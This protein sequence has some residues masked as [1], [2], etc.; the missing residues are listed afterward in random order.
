MKEADKLTIL[1]MAMDAEQGKEVGIGFLKGA[2]P[3]AWARTLGIKSV[4]AC[5]YKSLRIPNSFTNIA[6]D[7]RK[8]SSCRLRSDRQ[9]YQ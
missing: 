6:R 4:F 3:T 1:K 7:G 9:L 2:T 5:K 8:T